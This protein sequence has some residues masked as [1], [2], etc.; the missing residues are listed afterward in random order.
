MKMKFKFIYIS[1]VLIGLMASCNDDF[2]NKRPLQEVPEDLVWSDAGLAE[3]FIYEIYNGFGVGG[4]YE[5]QMAS[6]T[7]EA[8]FTHPGRGINTVTESRSNPADQGFIMDTYSYQNMYRRIRATNIAIRELKAPRFN[9]AQKAN[10]LLGEAYFLR[11]YFYQQ[12]LRFY[13]AVPLVDVVYELSDADLTKER[14]TYESCVDFIVDDCDSAVILMEGTAKIDGRANTV[15]ALALKARV[16]LYA[17]SDLHDAA[18]AKRKSSVISGYSNPEFLAYTSGNRVTRWQA[19]KD[20]AK[21]VLDKT[22]YAYKLDLVAPV[23]AQEGTANYMDI[24]MGGGSKNANVDGKRDLILGRF[25]NDIKDERGGWVGRDNGPN[26]YHNWAGNSPTQLLV[27]DYELATGEKFSWA[28]AAHKGSP[29]SNRDPRFYAT[30]LYDGANWKPRTDDV[31][32]RDPNNQIQTGRYEV[33]SGSGNKTAVFGLDMRNSPIED[34]NG[35]Y[36][37]YYYRKFTDPNPAIVDQNTRQQIP[38]PL[39]RYTE[40]VLNYVEACIELGEEGEAKIWLNKIRFRAGMPAITAT[41]DAL[42]T[43]YRNERRIELAYEEHR[44]FDARR[45]MIANETLGRKV[46]TIAVV[47]ALKP[48]AQVSV[49]K[50]DV[51]NY[52]YNYTVNTL[53]P[54]IENRVWND[55][56]YFTSFHRDEI[57]RNTKLLQNPGY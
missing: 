50:Y 43:Q 30:I 25:F 19:A 1:A 57:N 45:W 13:G 2:V 10:E 36:T 40:A 18:T 56:M 6:M 52:N 27:D 42:K 48:G 44:F 51:N 49:Y 17:A 7:D 5:Q 3:A 8:L 47:G 26:G 29:Y 39:L 21:A 38:W 24:A 54:G 11:A 20:A 14:S 55:K 35:T 46:T 31:K 16:L 23:T 12:L 37:G 28:N 15:A 33:G 9:D 41:G 22:E 4:F 32:N 34:W 53:N